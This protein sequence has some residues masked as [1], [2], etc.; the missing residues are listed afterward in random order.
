[1]KTGLLKG[2]LWMQ[3]E[4]EAEFA[5]GAENYTEHLTGF[6]QKFRR[7]VGNEGLPFYIALLPPWCRKVYKN[8]INAAI[9]AT[10]S[11]IPGVYLIPTDD[12]TPKPDSIHLDAA[13]Q[14]A[15][16]VRMA[17]AAWNMF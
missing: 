16:G 2:V 4:A 10:S 7:D 15:L 14:R 13:G 5:N 8:D 9:H 3:G 11:M 12:L 17:D 6:I 1:M